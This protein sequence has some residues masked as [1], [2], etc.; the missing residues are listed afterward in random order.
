M[1]S[2]F[3]KENRQMSKLWIEVFRWSVATAKVRFVTDFR[4]EKLLLPLEIL[5][6]VIF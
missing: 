2:F 3:L 1:Y 5:A 4:A 6:T